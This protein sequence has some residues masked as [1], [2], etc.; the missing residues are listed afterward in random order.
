MLVF[1]G[2]KWKDREVNTGEYNDTCLL[3]SI[4]PN[5]F[6]YTLK[7]LPGAKLRC[8]DKFFGNK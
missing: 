3:L 6:H 5:S 4:K 2:S 7:H 8:A 1:G